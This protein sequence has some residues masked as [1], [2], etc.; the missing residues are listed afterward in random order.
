[1]VE[2]ILR[3][4][5]APDIPACRAVKAG[6]QRVPHCIAGK[7]V[8]NNGGQSGPCRADELLRQSPIH[9]EGGNFPLFYEDVQAESGGGHGAVCGGGEEEF[10]DNVEFG[11]VAVDKRVGGEGGGGRGES[12]VLGVGGVDFFRLGDGGVG[13]GGCG[14]SG[15]FGVGGVDFFRLGDG[16]EGGC[17]EFGEFF[18][19]DRGEVGGGDSRLD[20]AEIHRGTGDTF[21]GRCVDTF[22]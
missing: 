22:L 1:M 6:R 2:E 9:G 10:A 4:N 5:I 16:G 21:A 13:G 8:A 20:F 11:G 15:V 19:E 17:V 14:E 12:G 3:R 18:G 7:V